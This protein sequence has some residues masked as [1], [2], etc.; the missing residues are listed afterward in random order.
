MPDPALRVTLASLRKL[1]LGGPLDGCSFFTSHLDFPPLIVNITIYA[2]L[3]PG[4]P[5]SPRLVHFIVP[6]MVRPNS[7]LDISCGSDELSLDFRSGFQFDLDTENPLLPYLKEMLRLLR[8][9]G[10]ESVTRTMTFR[11][12][13]WWIHDHWLELLPKVPRL[14]TLRFCVPSPVF[15]SFVAAIMDVL[16][17]MFKTTPENIPLPT[18]KKLEFIPGTG[19]GPDRFNDIY[20]FLRYRMDLG[21]PLE[22]VFLRN[23]SYERTTLTVEE[24]GQLRGLAK[25]LTVL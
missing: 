6:E 10:F 1:Q 25:I 4:T 19:G 17:A 24:E 8:T 2:H 21:F 20:R 14:Q 3:D 7:E 5:T 23:L 9:I 15:A 12:Q 22:V 13:C 11:S 16:P 18:L